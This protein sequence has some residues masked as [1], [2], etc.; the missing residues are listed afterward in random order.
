LWEFD[1]KP[2]SM[3]REPKTLGHVPKRK[4][5][6]DVTAVFQ[7]ISTW[8]DCLCESAAEGRYPYR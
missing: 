1:L 3:A 6:G 5:V 4:T 2:K 7:D 8:R